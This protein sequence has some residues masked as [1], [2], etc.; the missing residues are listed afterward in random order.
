LT[1]RQS[2]H[3]ILNYFD[4]LDDNVLK[5]SLPLEQIAFWEV[6][7]LVNSSKVRVVRQRLI[8]IAL[9]SVLLE[10]IQKNC[11]FNR[12]LFLIAA[13]LVVTAASASLQVVLNLTAYLVKLTIILIQD[14]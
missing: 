1:F 13:H 2:A 3:K 8:L 7:L 11:V 5:Y 6:L 14:C 4:A 12:L 10:I 9:A